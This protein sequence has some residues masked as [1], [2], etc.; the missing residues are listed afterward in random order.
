MASRFFALALSLALP[1]FAGSPYPDPKLT[2]G[3][4][5]DVTQKQVVATGYTVDARHVPDGLKWQ[6]FVRY[7]LASGEIIDH[8]QLHALLKKYEVDHFI[9]LELGGSNELANLWPEPYA[10]LVNGEQLGARQKDVVETGLHRLMKQGK[11]S[12]ADVRT[13]I[14]T[15]WVKA[16]HAIKAGKVPKVPSQH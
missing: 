1:A 7:H 8:D 11:L 14:R 12:L 2:P 10:N 4:V 9:S 5:A 6:V 16:Y 15:D 3:A 13:I